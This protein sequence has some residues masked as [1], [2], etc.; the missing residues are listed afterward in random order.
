M[1]LKTIIPPNEPTKPNSHITSLHFPFTITYATT[2]R[3]VLY[4]MELSFVCDNISVLLYITYLRYLR[5]YIK[6][7]CTMI[8][9][10][11]KQTN[12][13]RRGKNKSTDHWFSVDLVF[14]A[15]TVFSFNFVTKMMGK[16]EIQQWKGWGWIQD[17]DRKRK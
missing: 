12:K 8:S 6:Y 1:N 16:S 17:I 9:A 5:T 4:V 15:S 3:W 13:V 11:T 2:F 10:Q 14:V 7:M